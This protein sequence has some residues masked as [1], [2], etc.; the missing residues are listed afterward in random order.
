MVFEVNVYMNIGNKQQI[1]GNFSKW[2]N[3]LRRTSNNGRSTRNLKIQFSTMVKSTDYGAILLS[4][5][6]FPRL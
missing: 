3:L 4:V 1:Q 6:W 2:G 5:P